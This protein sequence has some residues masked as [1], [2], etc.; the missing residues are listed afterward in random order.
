MPSG[1]HA[2]VTATG[3]LD[4]G[5]WIWVEGSTKTDQGYPEEVNGELQVPQQ[6]VNQFPI[7]NSRLTG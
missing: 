2:E 7:P 3:T 1:S 4:S 6:L 5:D